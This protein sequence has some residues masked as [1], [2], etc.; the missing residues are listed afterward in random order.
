MSL[1]IKI[2]GVVLIV[3]GSA[4]MGWVPSFY[5]KKRLERLIYYKECFDSFYT[6]LKQKR[7]S[8]ESYFDENHCFPDEDANRWL[9]N[10]DR[11]I[12]YKTIEKIKVDSYQESLNHCEK[13]V[14]QL[15][16]T[17][18]DLKIIEEKSG[19]A[20]PLVMGAL[21]LLLAVLLF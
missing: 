20:R 19:K 6:D 7:R 12:I 5:Q 17:I 3:S 2:F 11:G 1:M 8:I 16:K 18:D 10:E 14:G 13:L 4:M 21:G 15:S 9:L